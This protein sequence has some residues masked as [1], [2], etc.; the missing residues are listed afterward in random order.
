VATAVCRNGGTCDTIG[1]CSAVCGAESKIAELDKP[2]VGDI[3]CMT[4]QP[5][6]S[7]KCKRGFG[8]E[9][10]LVCKDHYCSWA[11]S[12]ACPKACANDDGW[13]GCVTAQDCASVICGCADGKIAAPAGA[14][15]GGTCSPASAV[16]PTAC[17]AHGGYTGSTASAPDSGT[18]GPKKPGDPC[19]QGAECQAWSCTCKNGKTYNDNKVCQSYECA[20][21]AEACGLVCF[22]NGGWTGS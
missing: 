8:Y 9:A 4:S 15:S 17:A 20:T 19:Q 18:G 12:D 6:I 5:S 7:C 21:Q 1:A 3:T 14:C 13:A 2:C 22:S 11:P 10:P 16:C